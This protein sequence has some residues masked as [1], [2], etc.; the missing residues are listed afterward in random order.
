VSFGEDG[1]RGRPFVVAAPSGTGKTTVCRAALER[2]PRLRF[3][4]SHTTRKPR[5]AEGNGVDYHFVTSEEFGELVKADAFLEYAEYG[6]NLYG[7]SWVALE[8]PL[9][10]GWDLVVEIEVQGARQ[11]RER[12]RSACFIFLLPPDMASLGERL[13]G[14]GTDSEETIARRLAI[15]EQELQAIEFFDYAVVNREVDQAVSDLLEI[16]DAER[17]GR[18]PGARERHGRSAVFKK[19]SA[20][21]DGA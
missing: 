2:D 17:S 7:T 11:F 15:A 8:E 18:A 12:V 1:R 20:D 6:G 14:R 21:V 13:R 5:E 10:E 16:V 9:T 19:W 3:S 4:V